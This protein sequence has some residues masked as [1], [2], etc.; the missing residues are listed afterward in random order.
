MEE[1]EISFTRGDTYIIG[2]TTKNLEGELDT[3]YF[4]CRKDKLRETPVLFQVSLGDGITY[5]G[6]YEYQVVIGSDLTKDMPIG[7]YYYDLELSQNNSVKTALKG[8][9]KL[10]WD[11][12]GDDNE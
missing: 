6:N 1:K 8:K 2:F 4:T 11:V 3:A 10:T 9:L 5:L 7:N 12:T